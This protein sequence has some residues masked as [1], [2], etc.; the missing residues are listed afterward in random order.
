MIESQWNASFMATILGVAFVAVG[1]LGFLPN[2][3]I[4]ED[5]YFVVNAAHNFLHLIAGALLLLS[6]YFGIPVIMIRAMALI[7]TAIAIV[8]FVAPNFATLGGLIA[9]N[10]ADNWLHAVIAVVLLFISFTKP[11]ERS[12]TTAHM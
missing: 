11:M 6:P 9:M 10:M 5:G 8:G 1:L 3:L 2:P 12:V 4:Y 7:Y